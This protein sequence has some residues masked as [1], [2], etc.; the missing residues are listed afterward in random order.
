MSCSNAAVRSCQASASPKNNSNNKAEQKEEKKEEKKEENI[1]AE[2][3][4]KSEEPTEAAEAFL[5]SRWLYLY[6]HM[7]YDTFRYATD[8][9]GAK[10]CKTL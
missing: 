7:Q 10:M 9:N 8:C 5:G 2:K 4:E 3:V 6:A 1:E